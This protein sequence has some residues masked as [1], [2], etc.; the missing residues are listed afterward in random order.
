TEQTLLDL[1]LETVAGDPTTNMYKRFIDSRTREADFGA[2]S[3]FA[4]AQSDQGHPVIIGFGDTPVA[5]MNVRDIMEW[6]ARVLDELARIAAWKDGSPELQEF[7]DRVRSRVI[8]TRRQLSKFV[9]SP[10][11]FGFRGVGSDWMEHLYMLNRE[12]GF[13]KSVTM[14][15]TLDAV[16]RTLADNRNAWASYLAKWKLIGVQPWAF[17]AK[18]NPDLGRR[19]QQE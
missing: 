17:V 15:S 13:R 6:R 12:G 2:K 11:G 5:K 14:K 1:F 19:A 10:P 18:P 9:N 7:N 8:T 3:V 4:S 16:E